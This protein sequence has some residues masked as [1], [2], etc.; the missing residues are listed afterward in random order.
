MTVVLSQAYAAALSQPFSTVFSCSSHTMEK[1]VDSFSSENPPSLAKSKRD[2]KLRKRLRNCGLQ[3]C[4][5]GAQVGE[6]GCARINER[7]T[8]FECL[9]YPLNHIC[10]KK[11]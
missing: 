2:K 6:D 9:S 3:A 10:A 5:R 11:S 8:E 7:V 1:K 4:G